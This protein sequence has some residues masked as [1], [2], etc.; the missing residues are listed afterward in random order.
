MLRTTVWMGVVLS[1]YDSW[2][3]QNVFQRHVGD[4]SC[5]STGCKCGIFECGL[6][7]PSRSRYGDDIAWIPTKYHVLYLLWAWCTSQIFL[8]KGEKEETI[9]NIAPHQSKFVLDSFLS[10]FL[11]LQHHLYP[12]QVSSLWTSPSVSSLHLLFSPYIIIYWTP[13]VCVI[14]NRR[15]LFV[16]SHCTFGIITLSFL[17]MLLRVLSDIGAFSWLLFT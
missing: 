3:Y 4:C 15:L 12:Y 14:W 7:D 16:T 10:S 6:S 13:N 5:R 11:Y 1:G 2:L 8:L 17:Q 9:E